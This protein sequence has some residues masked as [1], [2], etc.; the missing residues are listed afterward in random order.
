MGRAAWLV[1]G[2]VVAGLILLVQQGC[3]PASHGVEVASAVERTEEPVPSD[4]LP[5]GT[6]T[7]ARAEAV[8][9][10]SSSSAIHTAPGETT[11]GPAGLSPEG[12]GNT[13]VSVITGQAGQWGLPAPEISGAFAELRDH[14][15]EMT[16]YAPSALP[17]GSG[18]H[19]C[20]WPASSG[21]EY[22]VEA[23][24]G[25][26]NPYVSGAATSPEVRVLLKVPSGWVEI[27]EGVRGDLGELPYEPA[28]EVAG[29]P[30]RS[31]RLL[32]GCLVQ[33][34][35]NGRWYA[36]YGKG[37]RVEDVTRIAQGMHAGQT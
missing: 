15:G 13:M 18:L 36:V 17:L 30:A 3:G 16:L 5:A 14:S 1:S 24:S 12:A 26:P 7:L 4:S 2:C 31:Y 22:D 10:T 6:A 34:S 23:D 33:W 29:H 28:G 37:V 19:H 8:E 35:D 9:N 32:G 25:K 20:W 11:E 21:Q 27:L